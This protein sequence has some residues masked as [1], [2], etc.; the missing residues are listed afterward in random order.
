M[1]ILIYCI[2]VGVFCFILLKIKVIADCLSV[3]KL[4]LE[5]IKIM[6][7]VDLSDE[8]KESKI[9]KNSISLFK[10]SVLISVKLVGIGVVS[11]LP[12]AIAEYSGILS[13]HTLAVFA[14]RPDVILYTSIILLIYFKVSKMIKTAND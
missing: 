5:S 10:S 2:S 13:I 12:G 4:S 1:L 6:Q 9:Q 14:L 3:I 7:T 8:E 11:L